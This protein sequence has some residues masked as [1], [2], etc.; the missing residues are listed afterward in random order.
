[1]GLGVNEGKCPDE[2]EFIDHRK[3][4]NPYKSKYGNEWVKKISKSSTLR[5]VRPISDLVNHMAKESTKTMKGTKYQGK[6]MFYHDSLS[7]LT[8]KKT[9]EWMK[10]EK[11]G[12]KNIFDMWIKPVIEWRYQQADPSLKSKL[13]KSKLDFD[14][15][16]TWMTLTK[17]GFQFGFA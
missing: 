12:E 11:I 4:D 17:V 6:A 2:Y 9:V 10:K 15:F 16:K 1:M 7:Q 3:S 5:L 13:S 14:F 8:E